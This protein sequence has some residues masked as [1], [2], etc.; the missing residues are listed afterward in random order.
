MPLSRWEYFTLYTVRALSSSHTALRLLRSIIAVYPGLG[1]LCSPL[2]A[3][4]FSHRERWSFQYLI[5]VGIAVLDAILLM[6]VFRFK[7]QEGTSVHA[8]FLATIVNAIISMPS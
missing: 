3:T 1:A 2:S 7:R 4:Q 6:V 8:V 5:S